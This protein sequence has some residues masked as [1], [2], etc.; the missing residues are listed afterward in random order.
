MKLFGLV[1]VAA[2]APSHV[3]YVPADD[4]AQHMNDAAAVRGMFGDIVAIGGLWFGDAGCAKQFEQ[5]RDD[6]PPDQLDALA[7]CLAGLHLQASPRTDELGDVIVLTYPPGIEVEARV[8][9]DPQLGL[10]L[11]WIGYSSRRSIDTAPTITSDALEALRVSGDR[12]G[13]IEPAAAATL[14]R[15]PTPTSHGE[16]SWLRV[17][18]DATG[19]VTLADPFETTSPGAA[20]AFSAAARAWTFKP[21]TIDG[22]AVPA[23][24]MKQLVYPAGQGPRAEILPLPP[25]PSKSHKPAIVLV[26]NSQAARQH[27]ATRTAGS[28]RL[29][30]SAESQ[31]PLRRH[32]ASASFLLCVD[33]SGAVESTL[34]LDSTS[35]PN[36]DHQLMAAMHAWRFAPYVVNDEAEP[37]CRTV[38]FVFNR[39]KRT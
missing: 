37:V 38:S 8:I 39:R 28:M 29:E 18:I 21:F 4:F 6:V 25:P 36:L 26:G 15:D 30:P 33:D 19:A 31:F 35:E 11:T 3:K 27:E 20:A 32:E 9:K 10:Q 2:C 24:S 14:V 12:N 7:R 34:T 16:Y 5:P 1:V 13:P 22:R 17:C 23:C